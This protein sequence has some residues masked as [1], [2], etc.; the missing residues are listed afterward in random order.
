MRRNIRQQVFLFNYFYVR[1]KQKYLYQLM[2]INHL[3]LKFVLSII[4]NLGN[5]LS[6]DLCFIFITIWLCQK[7]DFN[8]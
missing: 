3:T 2:A 5:I 7:N 6:K 4:D 1:V 8:L